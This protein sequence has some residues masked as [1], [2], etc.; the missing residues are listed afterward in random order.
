MIWSLGWKNVWRNKARSFVV[1]VAV[2]LGLFGGIMATGIMQGWINQR[3]HDSIY[4]EISHIQIHHPDY[5]NNEEMQFMVKEFEKIRSLLDTLPGIIAYSPRTKITAMAQSER[6]ATGIVIHG[7]NPEKEKKVSEI[8]LNIISGSYFEGDHVMPSM[9]ISSKIAEKLKLLNYQVSPEK[10]D[11]M[12][13]MEFTE[14]LRK[15][16]EK[17]GEKRY[18]TE[19][20]FRAALKRVLSHKEYNALGNQ[21]VEMFSFYRIRSKVTLTLQDIDGRLVNI[22]FRIRGIYKTNNSLF[23][24]TTA[25][26]DRNEL[27]SNLKMAD[28]DV[29]EIAV[30]CKDNTSAKGIAHLLKEYIPGNSVLSWRQLSPEIAMYTD[31]SNVMGYIYVGIIL[32]ALAFGIVN[33][34]LMSVLE[35]VRELGMLMSIGMNKKRVFLMIMLESVF[36]T[37]T[38]ALVGIVLCAVA[39]ERFGQSGINFGMWAEGFEAVGYAAVVYPTLTAGNYFGIMALVIATGIV[40]SIWP[41]RKALGLNPV[42]A[43]RTE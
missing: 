34:M 30:L 39:I 17:M 6:A 36:L 24:G 38:G 27:N 43:L 4:N 18:R 5:M 9:L 32:F 15:R 16:I 19:K 33:T 25:F 42:E 28:T 7:I 13:T 41:A 8:H 10:L 29:H 11:S 12:K 26:V 20:D 23:D 14:E 22:T 37:F 31:F 21:L 3:I 40:A 2:M 1:I 35:R